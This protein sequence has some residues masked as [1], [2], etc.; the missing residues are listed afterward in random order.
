MDRFEVGRVNGGVFSRAEALELG[1][2]DQTL[3]AAL[4]AGVLRRLRRGMYVDAQRYAAADDV[5]K[6][7]LH[8]RAELAAQ[9]GEVALCGIS[10]AA[11]HGFAL[12]DQ[13]LSVVHLLRLDD[14]AGRRSGAVNQHR[15]KAV[16]DPDELAVVQ[17]VRVVSPARAVWEVVCRSSLEGGV[18]TADSALRVAG[19]GLVPEVRALDE[20]FA[21]VPGSRRG[22]LALRLADH[23]SESPGESVTRVQCYR[24]GIPAPELQHEVVD[25]NGVVVARTDFWWE[26]Q[27]HAGEFDGMIKYGRLLK[28]GQTSSDVVVDEK[29]REDEVRATEECGMTRFVWWGVMPAQ[30]RRT[31]AKL[32]ASLDRSQRLYGRRSTVVV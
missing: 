16:V 28:E 24:Y 18:V 6:H 1:E 3:A 32:Q 22:R 27:R 2:T 21:Q 30:A 13:D 14:G 12:H 26:E 7:L 10:A 25:V 29:A 15:A 17:G 31:M 20:R 4:R 11:L 9:T 5:G 23:R 19:L 8:V